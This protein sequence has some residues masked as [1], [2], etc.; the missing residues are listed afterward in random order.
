MSGKGFRIEIPVHIKRDRRAR[1]VI[2][3]GEAPKVEE[4]VPR[5]AR[6]LA[7]AH[8]WEG[9]VRRGEIKDYA[10]IA[11]LTGLTRGRVTQICSLTLLAPDI[12]EAILS[13]APTSLDS[14]ALRRVL[15]HARWEVQRVTWR[16]LAKPP[17][18]S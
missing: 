14:R 17:A 6:L 13:P 4:P 5:I 7:L 9:M 10:E 15:T 2:A 3:K 1:K 8:K 18:T 12:Q 16:H 11:R